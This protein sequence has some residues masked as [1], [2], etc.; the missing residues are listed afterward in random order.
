MFLASYE[1]KNVQAVQHRVCM[2][3][4]WASR[5]TLM[6]ECSSFSDTPA[7]PNDAVIIAISLHPNTGRN[8]FIDVR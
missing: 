4:E 7:I 2:K 3:N 1:L 5:T 8:P 6:A